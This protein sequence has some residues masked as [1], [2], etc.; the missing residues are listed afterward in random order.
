[1]LVPG[2]ASGPFLLS[3]DLLAQCGTEIVVPLIMLFNTCLFSSVFPAGWKLS[4]VTA[5]PKS[6]VNSTKLTNWRPISL[7]HPLSKVFEAVIASRLRVYLENHILLSDHQYSF[8]QKRSTELLATMTVQQW[9]D[10]VAEGH[11]V[12]AVFLDCRKAFD[13]AEHEQIILY[14]GLV[15]HQFFYVTCQITCAIATRR[16]WWIAH[17]RTRDV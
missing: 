9:M 14:V 3:F 13:R 11:M 15:S 16:P 1:M 6:S 2:K 5:I 17:T 7:L 10:E 4:Y 12:D 8:R